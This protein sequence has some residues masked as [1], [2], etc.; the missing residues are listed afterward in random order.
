MP[1]KTGE[2]RDPYKPVVFHVRGS[3]IVVRPR[4]NTPLGERPFKVLKRERTR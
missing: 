1:R 2:L 3:R 4:P